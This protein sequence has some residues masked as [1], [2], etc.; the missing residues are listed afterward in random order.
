MFSMPTEHVERTF[1]AFKPDAVQRGLIGEI[2]ERFERAGF[3]IAALKMV[4]PGDE[5]LEQHY[6]EHKGK[7][8]YPN[9]KAFMQEGS[10]IA[11]VLEG[12]NAAERV[13]ELVGD[14]EPGEADPGTIRGDYAHVHLEHADERGKTVRNIIHAAEPGDA[15][16]EISIWFDEGEIHDY[17]RSDFEHV[18]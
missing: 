5:T 17:R 12:V 11:A 3:R 4:Q 10:V 2:V 7:S 13:R 14:T 18:L 8:F 1:I 6:E 15:D 16:R 9:L